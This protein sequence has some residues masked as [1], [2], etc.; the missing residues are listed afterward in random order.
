MRVLISSLRLYL[1]KRNCW[2][3]KCFDNKLIDHYNHKEFF[4]GSYILRITI[5]VVSQGEK[6]M[7]LYMLQGI[8]MKHPEEKSMALEQFFFL[9][10]WKH[11]VFNSKLLF[12]TTLPCHEHPMASQ[13]HHISPLPSLLFVA[14]ICLIFHLRKPASQ[15]TIGIL[16]LT[17]SQSDR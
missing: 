5:L 9:L 14:Y 17:E 15:A 13:I 16:P 10:L 11:R 7:R 3:T 12:P 8:K 2:Q 4:C 6:V 1:L